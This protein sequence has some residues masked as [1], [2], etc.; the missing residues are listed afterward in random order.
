MVESSTRPKAGLTRE[1]LQKAKDL[2]KPFEGLFL[3]PYK[4]PGGHDTVGWGHKIKPNEEALRKGISP[5]QAETLLERDITEAFQ[6]LASIGGLNENQLVASIDLVFNVGWRQVRESRF[7][8]AL[9]EAD[10]SQA[11]KELVEFCHVNGEENKGLLRRRLKA[12]GIFLL[13]PLSI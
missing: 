3:L 7:L 11:A 10:F 13:P 1:V 5:E 8:K 2:I 6:P 12:Q 9:R 4:C